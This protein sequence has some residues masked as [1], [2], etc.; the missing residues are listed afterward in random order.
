[1]TIFEAWV[2]LGQPAERPNHL[3]DAA[4][5]H[6]NRGVSQRRP[7]KDA[8]KLVLLDVHQLSKSADA[9]TRR[10]KQRSPR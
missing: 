6:S 3:S 5:R 8:T 4:L 9:V 2:D 1:M 7:T 10:P